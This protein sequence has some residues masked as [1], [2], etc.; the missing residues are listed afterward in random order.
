MKSGW[1][2]KN[3]DKHAVPF[4]VY[5]LPADICGDAIVINGDGGT[6]NFTNK[7]DLI[8]DGCLNKVFFCSLMTFE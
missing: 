6:P 3:S 8:W 4:G 5:C 7:L 2:R 1:K